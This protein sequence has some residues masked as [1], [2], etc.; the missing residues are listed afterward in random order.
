M[1]GPKDQA[2][3]IGGKF[4]FDAESRQDIVQYFTFLAGE[5]DSLLKSTREKKEALVSL[6]SFQ[7]GELRDDEEMQKLFTSADKI[8]AAIDSL[9]T[10]L[11]ELAKEFDIVETLFN[12]IIDEVKSRLRP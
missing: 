9:E 1:A 10:D 12:S 4:S 6:R 11:A 7:S 2:E 5:I 8:Q 3:L